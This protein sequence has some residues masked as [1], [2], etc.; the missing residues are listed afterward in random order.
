MPNIRQYEN[1]ITKITPSDRGVSAMADLARAEATEG[2]RSSNVIKDMGND[3]GQA[4]S[5]SGKAVAMAREA[6]VVRPELSKGAAAGAGLTNELTVGWNELAAGTDVNDASVGEKFRTE[7][8]LPAIEKFKGG[9]QTAEGQKWAESYTN[10]LVEHM[11][12]KIIADQASRAGAAAKKNF[13]TTS[14]NLSTTAM[15]D[16]TSFDF[17]IKQADKS[18]ADIVANTPN[19]SPAAAAQLSTTLTQQMKKEIAEAAIVGMARS[20][21]DA[22]MKALDSG[23]YKDYIDGKEMAKYIK[24]MQTYKRVEERAAKQEERDQRKDEAAK[25]SNE[26]VRST[27]D[28]NTGEVR[29]TQE[30]FQRLYDYAGRLGETDPVMLRT[31]FEFGQREIARERNVNQNTDPA[32]YRELSQGVLDGTTTLEKIVRAKTNGQLSKQDFNDVVQTFTLVQGKPQSPGLK[33]AMDAAEKTLMVNIPGLPGRDPK[34][35]QSY[36]QFVNAFLPEYLK[37]QQNG[38]LPPNAL[39]FND[40]N[41]LISQKMQP[42]KRSSAQQ[43]QDYVEGIQGLTVPMPAGGL[44]DVKNKNAPEELRGI[45]SLHF[46]KTTGQYYDATE[47]TYY[48]KNP[49]TG[50]YE[51]AR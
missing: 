28:P 7:K 51:R 47:G 8:L 2:Y 21:P 36:A 12:N 41:S 13:E 5:N 24:Q 31:M 9:F 11:N 39:D 15:S 29:V 14:N 50:K 27:I 30:W 16:P 49:A 25:W 42:Y 33:A 48:S 4:V 17:L 34:G 46:N 18:A 1:P 40:A 22:A 38:K 20:N 3:F 43:M 23:K 10:S 44:S 32:V 37:L 35:A 45:A 6:F 19:L 26:M